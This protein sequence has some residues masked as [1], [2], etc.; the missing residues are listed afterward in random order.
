MTR[1]NTG[2]R[3]LDGRVAIVTGGS[4]G[5]GLTLSRTLAGAG[6]R[7]VIANRDAARGERAAAALR[8]AGLSAVAVPVDVTKRPSVQALVDAV[9]Q[10]FRRIDILV[11]N[12]GVHVRNET[13]NLTDQEWERLLG[14]NV[15]GTFLCCQVVGRHM[16]RRRRG[17]IVNLAT[18]GA[19]I[20]LPRGTAYCACK[21]AV[22]HFTSALACE[23]GKFG[24]RVNAVA[25][26][27][28]H[29]AMSEEVWED[30]RRRRFNAQQT[31]LGRWGR[32]EDVAAAILYLVSDQ[33]AYVTGHVLYVDGGRTKW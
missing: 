21:A 26:G 11:N 20:Y 12:A 30:P 5:I 29:T 33:A 24:V 22:A 31:P 3:S 16:I 8:A 18:M 25:P 1:R 19:A 13:E 10:R 32:P 7:V 28:V 14:V 9:L 23:W 17:T 4:Q 2:K 27:A 6:A 15:T